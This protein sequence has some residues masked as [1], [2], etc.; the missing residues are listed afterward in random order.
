ML[1]I[2]I[3]SNARAH[4]P[5]QALKPGEAGRASIL[6]SVEQ[7]PYVIHGNRARI[8][9]ALAIVHA[10]RRTVS[11]VAG[12]SATALKDFAKLN[13]PARANAFA[14]WRQSLAKAIG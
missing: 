11:P 7:Y 9:L 4:A 6:Y 12:G 13:S 10:A 8:R 2:K 1:T 5:H 14:I 3:P